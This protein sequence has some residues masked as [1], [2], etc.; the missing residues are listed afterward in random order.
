MM[1]ANGRALVHSSQSEGS[2]KR[3]KKPLNIL[4]GKGGTFK[5]WGLACVHLSEAMNK[6]AERLGANESPSTSD[7]VE[8]VSSGTVRADTASFWGQFGS[9]YNLFIFMMLLNF[10]IWNYQGCASPKFTKVIKD[11]FN[12]HEVDIA[13]FLKTRVSGVKE[14]RISSNLGFNYSYRVESR[15]YSGGI[16]I[17]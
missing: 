13:S 11:Y 5:V 14:D 9:A 12:E 6:I 10:F 7:I 1:V 2:F 16:W 17:A 3:V 8:G 15:G 4:K